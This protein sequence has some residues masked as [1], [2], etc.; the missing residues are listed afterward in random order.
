M[1]ILLNSLANLDKDKYLI[2]FTASNGDIHGKE[3]NNL[4][5]DFSSSRENFYFFPSLGIK[6]YLTLLSVSDLVVGNSSSGLHEAPSMNIP[7]LDVGN[8]Q[9][10]RARSK[11]VM[12]VDINEEKILK[13]IN[14]LISNKDKLNYENPY[15][16]NVNSSYFI[17]S[18]IRKLLMMDIN[19]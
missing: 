17:Y 5:Q 11:S 19:S 2:I 10:G 16:S 15:I 3:F 8:R 14:H 13:G 18:K 1:Q 6:K 12:N 7:T 9:D 4:I